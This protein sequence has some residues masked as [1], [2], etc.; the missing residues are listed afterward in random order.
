MKKKWTDSSDTPLPKADKRV[1]IDKD[2]DKGAY[3]RIP[4]VE[5]EDTGLYK[6]KVSWEEKSVGG[7]EEVI[8]NHH[9]KG[10]YAVVS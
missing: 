2:E 9:L 4:G 6:C 3:L 5:G 10:S 1:R 8:F 7:E